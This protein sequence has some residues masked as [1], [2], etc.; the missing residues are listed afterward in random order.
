MLYRERKL[1][2]PHGSIQTPILFPVRNVGKRSSD[3]TP[4]YTDMIPDLRTGM[5]NSRAIRLRRPLWERLENGRSLREEMGVP[6]N[7]VLF[8]DSGGFDFSSEKIDTTPEETLNTQQKIEADIYG[9][10]DVPLSKGMRASENQR[11]VKE[12][13]DRALTASENHSGDALLFGSVHGYDPRTIR[14]GIRHLE[15]HG[16]FDG[17]AI[18]SMVPIRSDYKRVTKILLAARRSTDKH[19]HVYG[20]GGLVY[21][22]LLLYLG[23]DSFDSSAFIRSAGNRNYLI[24]G[25]GGTELHSI[26]E[27]EYLPCSCPICGSNTLGEIRSNRDFL[28]KHNLW[29]LTTELRRFRYIAAT[30]TDVESYLDLRFEGNEVTKRAYDMAKQQMRRLV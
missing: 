10:V 14:N 20:L 19:I 3:N 4:E 21:Q 15:K 16:E 2:T 7:T 28:T 8:A 17:Y 26:E 24:P 30:G 5:V 9:T 6:D 22:P 12:N 25:F 18:G 13:I 27:L 23:M 29:A 1:E 11:R